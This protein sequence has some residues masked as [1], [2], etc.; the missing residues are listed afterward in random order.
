MRATAGRVLEETLSEVF[1]A[2]VRPLSDSDLDRVDTAVRDL[3]M[4]REVAKAVFAD[5]SGAVVSSS[6]RAG[7]VGYGLVGVGGFKMD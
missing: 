2:G 3:K 7:S 5:V 1:L 6:G 4:D